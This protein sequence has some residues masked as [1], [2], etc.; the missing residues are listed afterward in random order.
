MAQRIKNLP[1]NVGDSGSTSGSG[2]CPEEE[3]GNPAPVLS[4]KS[5]EERRLAGYSP[6]SCKRVGHDLV[7][8]ATTVPKGMCCE[9]W[10]YV[11]FTIHRHMCLFCREL[12]LMLV[13]D[14][15]SSHPI[16]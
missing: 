9:V 1:A 12:F 15:V 6:W 5:Y 11:M 7:T 14:L 16:P 13:S 3:S 4:G 8:K 2:R 10:N